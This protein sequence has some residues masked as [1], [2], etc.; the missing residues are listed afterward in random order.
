VKDVV[1]DSPCTTKPETEDGCSFGPKG[2]SERV[3]RRAKRDDEA[4]QGCRIASSSRSVS[5]RWVNPSRFSLRVTF[6]IC[7]RLIQ[8]FCSQTGRLLR[9]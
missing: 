1:P 7:D 6:A 2:G 3:E 8:Y 5:V 9:P 4:L